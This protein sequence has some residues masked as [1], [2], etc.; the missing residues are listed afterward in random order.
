MNHM[1]PLRNIT[2]E[3]IGRIGQA[4]LLVG[5][6][7]FNNAATITHVVAA[8]ASGL[9]EH[10]PERR[11]ALIIAD[12][13]STLDDTRE[14][15]LA[16]MKKHEFPGVVGIYRGLPGK[17][18]AVRM[19]FAAARE[20]GVTALALLDS[21]LRSVKPLWVERLLGPVLKG[22]YE[23]V[24]PLY[25]RY[26]FDGTITN[27]V[28][29][30]MLRCL[31]GKRVRQPIGGEFAFSGRLA[32]E[33][34]A[35]PIWDTDVAR[36]GI[37]I[38]LT[39]NALTRQVPMCQTHLGVK[40]HDAKDP[41]ASLEPMFRQ[42]V[43]TLFALM[44]ETDTFWTRSGTSTAV[45]IWGEPGDEQ[46]EAF[47]ID[48]DRLVENFFFSWTTLRGAWKSILK[49]ET[50]AELEACV[51]T[52]CSIFQLDTDLWARILFE[53]AAAYHRRPTA[54]KQVI[55][56]LSPLYF[57]RVASFIR[58]VGDHSNAE[59]EAV[60]EEQARIFEIRKPYLLDLWGK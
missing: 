8:A 31:Y 40:V 5:I 46:P 21:D 15:A 22:G 12:G 2:R 20:L 30:N 24:A 58:R 10:F 55:E 59:A 16:E 23:F 48:Y 41:A 28:T 60:V 19:I 43:G 7:C 17:G 14:L 33:L 13:G 3:L 47:P 34:E 9:R 4:D 49:P 37:D 56:V 27:N 44:E 26:K 53:F 42:V 51:D 25:S 35:L 39:V 32:A 38:W 50:Y 18:S 45:D 36:F 57:A 52:G 54:K 29:Y 11:G 6:P 1:T